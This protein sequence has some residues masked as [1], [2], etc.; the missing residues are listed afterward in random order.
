MLKLLYSLKNSK[1]Q[2]LNKTL[3]SNPTR[4]LTS[5]P[6]PC[7][8]CVVCVCFCAVVPSLSEDPTPL[9]EVNN[10]NFEFE[11]DKQPPFTPPPGDGDFM[12]DSLKTPSASQAPQASS[13]TATAA[14]G[15][16]PTTTSSS[17]SSSRDQVPSSHDTEMAKKEPNRLM[18]IVTSTPI[19]KVFDQKKS[20]EKANEEPIKPARKNLKF[21]PTSN[22]QEDSKESLETTKEHNKSDKK[23]DSN[24]TLE[25]LS[26]DS[27]RIA[28]STKISDST[29]TATEGKGEGG[30][31]EE[32]TS[33]SQEKD[34]SKDNFS[35]KLNELDISSAS[36]KNEN[37]KR[38][39][40]QP[41][42][43]KKS[44]ESIEPTPLANNTA[45]KTSGSETN[46]SSDKA[47]PSS[48][49]SNGHLSHGHN[50][51]G[52]NSLKPVEKIILKENTPGQDLLEWC[53]EVTKE[54]P[55]VKVTNLTTS[56]RN[57]M[58]F[59]AII[60]HFEPSI[61]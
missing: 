17:S 2:I 59:C 58:A 41:L 22:S 52:N 29:I 14:A 34:N 47:P 6:R 1:I 43:L 38:P 25:E 54:Y 32:L 27:H 49:N 48:N 8:C 3:H 37:H 35:A 57:G 28:E 12:E 16:L 9:A 46:S 19:A 42:N 5:R 30:G 45:T 10:L 7:K 39:E 61:M 18:R 31:G 21:P 13:A 15:S 20:T 51:I 36:F 44:Y 40:L 26:F 4:P 60:H 56:W 24:N 33:D 55:N 53:K 23:E 50:G 11:S